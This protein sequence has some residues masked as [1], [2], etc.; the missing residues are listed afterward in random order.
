MGR[1]EENHQGHPGFGYH[2]VDTMEYYASLGAPPEKMVMGIP[3]YGRGYQIVDLENDGLYCP[4]DDGIRQGPYTLQKGIWGYNEIL[5]AMNNDTLINLPE[6]EPHAWKV[7]TDGCYKA[8]YMV[9]GPYW[10]GYDDVDSVMWKTRYINFRGFAGGMIW[11]ADTD[12]FGGN[13]GPAYPL[14]TSINQALADGDEYDPNVTGCETAPICDL[15]AITPDP[16][17]TTAAPTTTEEVTTEPPRTTSEGAPLG[18]LC[19]EH[20]EYLPYPGDCHKY[21]MCKDADG[22]G[23]FDIIIYT[24]GDYAFNP[25]IDACVD[26]NLPGNCY[27]CGNC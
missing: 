2:T 20:N 17:L 18:S 21:L 26:P 12:D 3:T 22:D 1:S 7:V 11:S 6:A 5:Q 27:L 23:E 4:T 10:I 9:N 8:P 16:D 14:L 15:N 13:D 24:C 25:N 19:D